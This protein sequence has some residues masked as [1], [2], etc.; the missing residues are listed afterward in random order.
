MGEYQNLLLS[1]LWMLTKNDQGCK[2][3]HKGG[4]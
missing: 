1:M 2:K 4:R 3:S